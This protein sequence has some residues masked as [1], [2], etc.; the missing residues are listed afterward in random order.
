MQEKK[1]IRLR[2]II[3]ECKY[4]HNAYIRYDWI[5]GIWSPDGNYIRYSKNSNMQ[6]YLK[7]KTR[8]AVRRSELILQGN[9]YRKY[10]EYSWE[11]Y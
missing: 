4:T 6:K 8:R 9:S 7:R 1:D 11:F 5:E 3:A 10:V 2:K